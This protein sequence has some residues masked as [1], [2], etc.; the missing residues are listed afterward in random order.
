MLLLYFYSVFIPIRY[1][2]DAY[3]INFIDYDKN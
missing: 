3:Y 1:K 2:F